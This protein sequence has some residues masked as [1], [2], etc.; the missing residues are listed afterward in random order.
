MVPLW[1]TAALDQAATDCEQCAKH[2]L[3][4]LRVYVYLA[5]RN[6]NKIQGITIGQERLA[7]ECR[8]SERAVRYA[9]ATLQSIGAVLVGCQRDSEARRN[10][11]GRPVN[12]Y[13]LGVEQPTSVFPHEGCRHSGAGNST[14]ANAT[15]NDDSETFRHS[16]AANPGTFRHQR[17][18]TIDKEIDSNSLSYKVPAEVTFT[19]EHDHYGGDTPASPPSATADDPMERICN[20]MD[21]YVEETGEEPPDDYIRFLRHLYLGEHYDHAHTRPITLASGSTKPGKS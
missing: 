19:L 3:K 9:L 4:A 13:F 5:G 8:M 21:E 6:Y 12:V 14:Y 16:G 18:A 10:P 11:T 2:A 20:A 7:T 1:V 17:A 15:V